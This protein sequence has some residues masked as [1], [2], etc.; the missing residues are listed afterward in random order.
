MFVQALSLDSY[1][2]ESLLLKGSALLELNK[3]QDCVLHFKEALKLDSTRYEA[4]K[5]GVT[6]DMR[7]IKVA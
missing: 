5:G 2:I 1:S 7:L 4:H 6:L 3:T